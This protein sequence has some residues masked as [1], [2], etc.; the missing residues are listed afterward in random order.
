MSVVLGRANRRASLECPLQ[1]AIASFCDPES[2]EPKF[3]HSAQRK[4]KDNAWLELVQDQRVRLTFRLHPNKCS[5]Y[6]DDWLAGQID[7]L[8]SLLA[9]PGVL[10]LGE[11]GVDYDHA[12]P[13]QKGAQQ[14]RRGEDP[15]GGT[16]PIL[17]NRPIVIHLRDA[18]LTQKQTPSEVHTDVI[19]ILSKLV[20]KGKLAQDHRIQLHYF[21][22]GQTTV[23]VGGTLP[24]CPLFH[25]WLGGA[26]HTS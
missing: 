7:L 15:G 20:R 2:R 21:R 22:G 11:V 6:T 26:V 10:G 3:L 4:R 5:D 19:R 8:K 1:F 17:G 24:Q 13:S 18:D 14:E 12:S 23:Q 9:L 25:E 16:L